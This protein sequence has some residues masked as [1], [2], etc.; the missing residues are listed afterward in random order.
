MIITLGLYTGGLFALKIML[1]FL[2]GKHA[3]GGWIVV[4][5][6]PLPEK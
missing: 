6:L 2:R 4:I 1:P 3:A 5:I